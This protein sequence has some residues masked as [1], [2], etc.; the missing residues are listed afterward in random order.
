MF[1]CGTGDSGYAVRYHASPQD[2]KAQTRFAQRSGYKESHA[3]TSA[4]KAVHA[5]GIEYEYENC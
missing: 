3:N 1:I 2:E 4:V 5:L